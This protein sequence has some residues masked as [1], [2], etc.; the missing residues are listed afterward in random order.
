MYMKY[1]KTYLHVNIYFNIHYYN[2]G[3]SKLTS[4]VPI[5]TTFDIAKVF[6]TNVF[7]I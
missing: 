5:G 3:N 6:F 7:F 1:E 4:L 2:S